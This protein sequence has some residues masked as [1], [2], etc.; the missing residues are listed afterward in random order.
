[1]RNLGWISVT[2]LVLGVVSLFAEQSDL[3]SAPIVVLTNVIDYTV[4]ALTLAEVMDVYEVRSSLAR[5]RRIARRVV[6]A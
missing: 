5:L 2:A 6:E 4:L 1:M 3:V